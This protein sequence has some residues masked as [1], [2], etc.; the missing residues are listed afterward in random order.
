MTW[1]VLKLLNVALLVGMLLGSARVSLARCGSCPGIVRER[2]GP[3]MHSP[4]HVHALDLYAPPR[5]QCCQGNV[6]QC[7]EVVLHQRRRS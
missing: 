1:F 3:Q 2:E 5:L 7:E 6:G 4:V